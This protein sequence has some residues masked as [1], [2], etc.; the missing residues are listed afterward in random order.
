[1]SG[2]R[3]TGDV[4]TCARCSAGRDAYEWG[5]DGDIDRAIERAEARNEATR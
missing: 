4:E 5:G 2:H 1:V 3:C